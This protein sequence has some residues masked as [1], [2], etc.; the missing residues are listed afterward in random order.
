M[1]KR[2]LTAILALMLCL[3]MV[4]SLASCFDPKT[5]DDENKQ[6]ATVDILEQAK[7]IRYLYAALI[8]EGF[9]PD[10][11]LELTKAWVMQ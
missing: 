8:M 1:S 5:P 11:A 7:L 3:S 6:D 9:K 10:E 4:L 2:L